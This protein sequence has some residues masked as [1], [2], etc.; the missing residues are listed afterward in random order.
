[1]RPLF[2]RQKND[3]L[4]TMIV[5]AAVVV[6]VLLT[7]LATP[8]IRVTPSLLTIALVAFPLIMGPRAV[9]IWGI[10]LLPPVILTLAYISN[11]GIREPTTFVVLRTLAYVAVGVLAVGMSEYRVRA[12]R[13][14]ISLLELLDSLKTPI[15]VSDIDGRIEFANQACCQLVGITLEE[16]QQLDFFK[17]FAVSG[18]R[19]KY[20]ERYLGLFREHFGGSES[21]M[22]RLGDADP[23]KTYLA[24]CSIMKEGK[25]KLLVSQI[26]Q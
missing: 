19:G 7:E 5:P 26:G 3:R 4:W 23:D 21:I 25:R 20:I 1:M 6:L 13:H 16:L 17:V 2:Q 12:E 22:I 24:Q 18:E 8:T 10:I 14:L 9:A 11:T 15:I